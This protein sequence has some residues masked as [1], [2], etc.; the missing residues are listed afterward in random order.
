MAR[1]GDGVEQL[2]NWLEHYNTVHP[3]KA[4][5]YR[6]PR[7]FCASVN[8]GATHYAVRALRRPHH[9]KPSSRA[10]CGDA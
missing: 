8:N 10:K 9:S 7:K 4:L 3:H 2:D 6:S 5:G 1:R